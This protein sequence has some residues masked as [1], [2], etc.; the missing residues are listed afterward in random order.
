MA[1][2]LMVSSCPGVGEGSRRQLKMSIKCGVKVEKGMKK[3]G[4]KFGLSFR[5]LRFYC[6]GQLLTGEELA[7]GLNGAIVRVEGMDE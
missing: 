4:A 2:V 3:F 6:D 5:K 1:T 7:G